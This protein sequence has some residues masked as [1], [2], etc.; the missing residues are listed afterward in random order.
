MSEPDPREALGILGG[1]GPQGRGLAARW[2]L[3]GHPVLVGS[4]SAQRADEAAARILDRTAGE[5]DVRGATNRE[6]CER[7]DIVV[8]AVPYDAQ[9]DLLPEL[10]DVIGSKLVVNVVNPMTFDDLGPI[11]VQVDA[12]SAAEECA[13]LLP[14][15]IVV[16]AFHDVPARRLWGVDRPVECDVLIC[17]DD[18]K[19]N[20]RVAHL[21]AE[22]PGMWGVDCGPLRNS[23]H[24]ENMTPVLLWINRYYRIHAGLKIDGIGR[25]GSSL[26]ARL[27]ADGADRAVAGE[28]S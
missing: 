21:A 13:E 1:T 18:Q 24:I 17:G 11:A 26:H 8:V 20:H 6:V 12:G 23:Q 25:D 3:A 28:S 14:D 5:G 27:G 16:S 22:I 10:A 19:A 2:A 9:V 4:R 15:A 7:A